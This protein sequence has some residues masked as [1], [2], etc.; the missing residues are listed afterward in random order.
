MITSG[1]DSTAKNIRIFPQQ[2]SIIQE[3]QGWYNFKPWSYNCK[4][5]KVITK[6]E[7]KIMEEIV[8]VFPV[9]KHRFLNFCRL[10][11]APRVTFIHAQAVHLGGHANLTCEAKGQEI[12]SIEWYT[13]SALGQVSI[14]NVR[15]TPFNFWRLALKIMF[16]SFDGLFDEIQLSF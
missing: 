14:V 13:Q 2:V 11:A 7:F 12:P 15:H 4:L 16:P 3:I 9:I 10:T 8:K 5:L 6:L 1:C